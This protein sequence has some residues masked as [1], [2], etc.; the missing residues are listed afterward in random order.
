MTYIIFV[1]FTVQI[2][3]V[4]FTDKMSSNYDGKNLH[5]V[6]CSAISK[7][8]QTDEIFDSAHPCGTNAESVGNANPNIRFCI[9]CTFNASHVYQQ[10]L[11]YVLQLL[12][13]KPREVPTSGA[14]EFNVT[15]VTV[16]ETNESN[17]TGFD[18]R[19]DD[20]N[21]FDPDDRDVFD[22]RRSDV[23]YV[24][25]NTVQR[26]VFVIDDS[27]RAGKYR[28]RIYNSDGD[29]VS[30]TVKGIIN[31]GGAFFNTFNENDDDDTYISEEIND[32]KSRSTFKSNTQILNFVFVS[33]SIVVFYYPK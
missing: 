32:D 11:N 19:D 31:V 22:E 24:K 8:K 2:I 3:F 12:K 26:V 9:A 27:I 6:Y 33:T 10:R 5:E 15:G 21:Y 13:Y 25:K 14:I 29:V 23:D 7:R 30:G 17:N 1:R 20:D 28:G 16:T 4:F 18:G